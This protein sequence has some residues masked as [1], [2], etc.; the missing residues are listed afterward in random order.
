MSKVTYYDCKAAFVRLDDFLDQHLG[1]DEVA[2]VRA[3]LTICT[4]CAEV[5]RFEESVIVAV[6]QKMARLD[7]PCDLMARLCQAL[8]RETG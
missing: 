4:E 6:R 7:V 1:D 8:D 2:A 3:H 5:Y